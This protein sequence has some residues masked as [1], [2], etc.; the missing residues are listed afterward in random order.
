[1]ASESSK[2]MDARI[3]SNISYGSP[4]VVPKDPAKEER[5][6]KRLLSEQNSKDIV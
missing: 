6:V 5:S 4:I 2:T 3:V 1:M